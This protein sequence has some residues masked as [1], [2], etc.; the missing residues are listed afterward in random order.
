[1]RD[2]DIALFIPNPK[3]DQLIYISAFASGDDGAIH[4]Y[5][6]NVETAEMTLLHR[7]TDVEQPF[8]LA[9]SSDRRFL[10]SVHEFE[11]GGVAAFAV[12]GEDGQLKR[13]NHQSS[14]GG[15]TCYVD[16]DTTG[17]TLVVANYNG[18][19]VAALPIEDDGSLGEPAGFFQHEG[20]SV[21][22]DRQAEPHAHCFVISPDNRYAYAADLGMDKLVN[23]R[24][25]AE[26]AVL[27]PNHQSFARTLPGAGPRHFTFHPHAPHA[28]VINELHNSVTVFDYDG[29]TG[30]LIEQQTIGTLPT[31]YDETSHTADLKITSDGKY[32]Y[33]TNRGHDSIACY[34]ID[35]DGR[36]SLL[37]IEPSLGGGPQ[38]L[39]ITPDGGLLLCAN[40]VEG[41][42][43]VFA[44]DAGSGEISAVGDPTSVP[45]PSCI[46]IA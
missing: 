31:D 27:S 42:V 12:T 11:E 18:G 21:R 19:S 16:V 41:N 30:T 14:G 17:K 5:R 9:L 22:L 4:A 25:D 7:A 36:L 40:M 3:S 20:S 24:L 34:A 33:G 8:F 32:L 46:M 6:L 13:L 28:Y 43:V 15:G 38:N 23:Y 44:I 45:S 35:T 39:A 26:S 29:A 37:G 1:M 10:Y 2:P